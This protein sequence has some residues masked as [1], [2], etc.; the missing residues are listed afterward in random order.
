[1][2][3]RDWLAQRFE[4]DRTRLRSV[5]YRMLG[6]FAE[7]DDAVQEAWIRLARSDADAIENLSG[8]LTT[9]VGRV[10]L[11]ML[12]SR[13][14]RR[15][16]S[17]EVHIPDPVVEPI[18]NTDPEQEAMLADSVGLALLLVLD[19]LSP[20]ERL[21]FVLHDM[22]DVPFQDI[23]QMLD[24]STDATKMLASRARRRLRNSPTEPDADL[25]QQRRVVD[26]FFAA[27]RAGDFEALVSVL[28]PDIVVRADGSPGRPHFTS[29]TRGAEAVASRAMSFANPRAVLHPALVNGGAGVVVTLNGHPFSILSFTVVGGKI[30]AIDGISDPDR[31][32]ACLDASGFELTV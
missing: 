2:D 5:A 13:R 14:S 29:L 30:V 17:L 7:A 19:T 23:A 20:A 31:M 25:D 6:S 24:R 11:D 4:Q 22:F 27:A 8:W 21:A 12:R 28:A 32:A 15:E 18:T 26:A 10:C 16:E 9:V 3:D 1:V